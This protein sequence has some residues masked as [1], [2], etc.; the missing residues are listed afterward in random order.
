MQKSTLLC[1]GTLSQACIHLLSDK[2]L[3]N[4]LIWFP[5]PWHIRCESEQGGNSQNQTT[6]CVQKAR[7]YPDSQG[8][9]GGGQRKWTC[10]YRD[11]NTALARGLVLPR[12]PS[13]LKILWLLRAPLYY[14]AHNASQIMKNI[15]NRI[16]HMLS[17]LPHSS[18]SHTIH[19][20]KVF[21]K[22]DQ[23]IDSWIGTPIGRNQFPLP[24]G[25]S[26]PRTLPLRVPSAASSAPP[27][28]TR[29]NPMAW[30]ISLRE[31]LFHQND[32]AWPNPVH[33]FFFSS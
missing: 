10:K 14:N 23:I 25:R 4:S 22:R 24:S 9:A 1:S 6:W 2:I 13:C 20:R 21:V 28:Q 30:K 11:E 31:V 8:G 32:V 7:W 29:T 3:I 12:L 33:S 16:N 5:S 18:F 19:F 17:T 15:Y 26:L 27:G